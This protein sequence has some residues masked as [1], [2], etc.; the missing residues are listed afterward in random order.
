MMKTKFSRQQ[1][2]K[3]LSYKGKPIR[4]S[5][6]F[7]AQTLQARKE[8]NQIFKI[9]SE[10]NYQPRRLYPVKLSFRYEGEIKTFPDTQKLREFSPTRPALQEIPKGISSPKTNK[11]TTTTT[12]IHN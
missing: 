12:K 9:L 8:W 1:G 5:S 11:Q 6:D 4:L 2:R 7:S 3:K 10:R